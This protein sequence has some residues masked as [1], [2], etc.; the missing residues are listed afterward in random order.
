MLSHII[1]SQAHQLNKGMIQTERNNLF[2]VTNSSIC[3]KAL[4]IADPWRVNL[5]AP[6]EINM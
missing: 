5:L 2:D 4:L 3:L 6:S 1:F